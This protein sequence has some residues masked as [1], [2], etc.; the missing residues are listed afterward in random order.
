MYK[1]YIPAMQKP[2]TPETSAK[3]PKMKKIKLE[4]SDPLELKMEDFEKNNNIKAEQH[5]V[6][7][8]SD[9]ELSDKISHNDYSPQLSFV[10]AAEVEKLEHHQENATV[11]NE[12]MLNEAVVMIKE[13]NDLI[14]K[15]EQ[16][17]QSQM[18]KENQ[19]DNFIMVGDT[20][21]LLT[22]FFAVSV[23]YFYFLLPML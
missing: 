12:E 20:I 13:Q 1:I 19:M 21:V 14:S 3:K 22:I 16:Q 17:L 18:Q 8:E 11:S 15:L 4:M 2:N 9:W 5:P 10:T 6:G 23:F 7:D